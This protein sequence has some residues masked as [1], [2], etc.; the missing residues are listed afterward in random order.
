MTQTITFNEILSASINSQNLEI[1]VKGLL[2][3][4]DN[5]ATDDDKQ[6]FVEWFQ[7]EQMRGKGL[8]DINTMTTK[9]VDHFEA[10]ED[11]TW[12]ELAE[13]YNERY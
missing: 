1:G 4:A 12:E 2:V 3:Y 5:N 7:D 6:N 13:Y 11:M 10:C 8:M 9:P